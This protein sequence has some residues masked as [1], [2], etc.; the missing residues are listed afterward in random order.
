MD[1]A[2]FKISTST[3]LVCIPVDYIVLVEACGNY[4]DIYLPGNVKITVTFQL[5]QIINMIKEQL[6][7]FKHLFARVGK[8][9]VVNSNYVVD[10]DLTSKTIMLVDPKFHKYDRKASRDALKDIKE[11][12][13]QREKLFEQ[14]K[15]QKSL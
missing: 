8:S 9:M 11:Q 6:P 4:C 2:H 15:Q 13:E 7:N 12:I 3:K 10:I 14:R 1:D 5:G